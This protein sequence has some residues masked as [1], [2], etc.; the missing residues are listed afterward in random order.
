MVVLL[1]FIPIGPYSIVLGYLRVK[2]LL[3]DEQ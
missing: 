1:K 2:L 3:E